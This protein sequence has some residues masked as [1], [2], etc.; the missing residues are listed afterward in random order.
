[1]VLGFT[2]DEEIE[3]HKKSLLPKSWKV[4]SLPVFKSYYNRWSLQLSL[5]TKLGTLGKRWG[6]ILEKDKRL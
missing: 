6:K 4:K 2:L 3:K 1:M 5:V